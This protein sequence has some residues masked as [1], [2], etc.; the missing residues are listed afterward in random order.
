MRAPTGSSPFQPIRSSSSPKRLAVGVGAL[1][2]VVLVDAPRRRRRDASIAGAKRA[3]SSLVQLVTTIGCFVRMPRSFSDAHDLQRRRARRARRRTCR[4]SAGCRGGC[5]HRPAARPGPSPARAREHRPHLVDAHA[6]ARPPRT[7]AGTAPAPRRRRRSA[8]G[9]CCRRRRPGPIFAI[10]ISESQSRSPSIRRFSPGAAMLLPMSTAS[11]PVASCTRALAQSSFCS[12]VLS[13]PISSSICALVMISGGDMRD[14]VAGGAD[15]DARAR[16][17]SR[18][19]WKA[20]LVGSPGD[21]L[22]LDRADQAHVADVDDVRRVPQRM[23]RLLP[24]RRQRRAP[25]S[26]SPSSRVGVE[27][28]RAPPPR[29]S[30]CPSRC[31]RGRTRSGAPARS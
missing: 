4:R 6:S 10:S 13:P 7:S 22:Q 19:A 21:R 24:V 18:K 12:T 11:V 28:A 26:N 31:S 1:I 8:S 15:Q 3:P 23:Q 29:R 5:R 16:R 14:D 27:R 2:G 30:G 25:R 20:R 17:R 9:G